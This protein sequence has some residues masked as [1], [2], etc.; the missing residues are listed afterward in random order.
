MWVTGES[1]VIDDWR[2]RTQLMHF[3]VSIRPHTSA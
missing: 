3:K 1:L 2:V